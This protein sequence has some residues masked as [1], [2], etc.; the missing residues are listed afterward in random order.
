M[1]TTVLVPKH[2]IPEHRRDTQS[3]IRQ[4]GESH[5]GITI[6]SKI[7]TFLLLQTSILEC[8]N[9]YKGNSM[10]TVTNLQANFIPASDIIGALQN[11]VSTKSRLVV[12]IR[13]NKQ[14]LQL[15]H[16]Q[17]LVCIAADRLSDAIVTIS[18]CQTL[19]LH[20]DTP[21]PVSQTPTT[22]LSLAKARASAPSSTNA[23]SSWMQCCAISQL[24]KR[25]L[26]ASKIFISHSPNSSTRSSSPGICTRDLYRLSGACQLKPHA[27]SFTTVS[28][29]VNICRPQQSWP[30]C[31]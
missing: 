8:L 6:C 9:Q 28:L 2:H 17:P 4:F 27:I 29:N 1:I 31:Y 23:T 5:A 19:K 13:S 18:R 16:S 22:L 11:I 12:S 21:K 24:W 7:C 30:P 20:H 14:L 25:S 26:S 15:A 10:Q 3:L